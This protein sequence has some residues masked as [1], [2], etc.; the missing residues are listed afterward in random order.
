M[1]ILFSVRVSFTLGTM[2]VET[3]SHVISAVSLMESSS[4]IGTYVNGHAGT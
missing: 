2:Q 3:D 4:L 1:D